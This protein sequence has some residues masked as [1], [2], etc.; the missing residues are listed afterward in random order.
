M[1]NRCMDVGTKRRTDSFAP[2]HHQADF[3]AT[4]QDD[5]GAAPQADFDILFAQFPVH[6][7]SLLKDICALPQYLP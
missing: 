3:G 6:Q 5:F 7:P 1:Y 2:T 4:P